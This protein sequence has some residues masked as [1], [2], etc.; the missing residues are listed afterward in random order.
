VIIIAMI[1]AAM[2]LGFVAYRAVSP[3]PAHVRAT[4]TPSKRDLV[5]IVQAK[6]AG[7]IIADGDLKIETVETDKTPANAAPAGALRD[8]SVVGAMVRIPL[9]AGAILRSGDIMP[10]G[11]RSFLATAL[12]PGARAISIAVDAV[13]GAA[14]LVAPNDRVDLLLTQGSVNAQP[15]KSVVVS[16]VILANVR[17]VAVDQRFVSNVDSKEGPG[18]ARTVTLEVTPEQALRVTTAEQLGRLAIAVR[19]DEPP[20]PS[21]IGH[22]PAIYGR[23]VAHDVHVAD[24]VAPQAARPRSNRASAAAAPFSVIYGSDPKQAAHP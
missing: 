5:T 11:E 21:T 2:G 18:L 15:Q 24:R 20:T 1:I 6:N 14:G 3:P 17:V 19:P 12:S 10:K 13:T 9:K 16:E 22:G 7:S 4:R 8:G 23:D